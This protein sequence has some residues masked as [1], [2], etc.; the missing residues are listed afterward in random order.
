MSLTTRVLLFD[1]GGVLATNGWDRTARRRAAEEFGFDSK[2]FQNRHE[3]VAHDFE[4]GQ[5]DLVGYLDR[6][7]FYRE[8]PFQREDI[9]EFIK[10]QTEPYND[11]LA[12]VAELA[13]YRR[14][15]LA[16][17][18]NESRELNEHRIQKLGLEKHFSIF[19]S[20]CYLGVRKP[21]PE[22][23]RIAI[24]LTQHEPAECVFIDDRL[25]NLEC[26]AREGIRTIHFAGAAGLRAE[27]IAQ[28]VLKK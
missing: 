12:I 11:S 26:A 20:S 1:V 17:L 8:R 10:H 28:G 14:Y 6:T 18:N 9:A 15:L 2:E 3:F 25:L 16:T 27:L 23:Y 13:A 7:L 19:L 4:T 5:L 21:E 22:T 24:D